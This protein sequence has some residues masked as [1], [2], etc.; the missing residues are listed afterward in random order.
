MKLYLKTKDFSVSGEFFE[1]HWDPQMDMLSTFPQPKDISRYYESEDYISHTDAKSSFTDKL[2]Q[3]VKRINLRNKTQII[4]SQVHKLKSLLDF[5][6]G[7]GDFVLHAQASGYEAKGIE[8]SERARGLA[9]RKGVSLYSNLKH[10]G[11]DKFQVITLWHVLEHLPNLQQQIIEIV[12]RLNQDGTLIVAVPNFK[13]FDAKHYGTYWAGYD[14]PRHLWHFSRTAIEKIFQQHNFK[15]VAVHPMWFDAF[16]VSMLS[17][18]YKG[19]RRY[20]FHAFLVGLWSNIKA[21]FTKEHSSLIY[22]LK[23]ENNPIG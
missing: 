16:Y 12:S 6:A 14:V 2:Y 9:E 11:E 22:V 17:E 23:R 15:I 20:L 5:G 4:D 7:T 21:C 8:P 13:S 19:N 10:T 1:L 3:W 18:K